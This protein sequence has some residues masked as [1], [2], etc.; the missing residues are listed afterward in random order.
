MRPRSDESKERLELGRATYI[1]LRSLLSPG[2]HTATQIGGI[3]FNLGVNSW[4]L[5]RRLY[6]SC[7]YTPTNT[8]RAFARGQ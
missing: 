6:P 3:R 4:S 2:Q 7:A 8:M 5:R 1:F